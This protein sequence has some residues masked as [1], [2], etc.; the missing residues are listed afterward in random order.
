MWHPLF[1][2]N[3][4]M[5]YAAGVGLTALFGTLRVARVRRQRWADNQS[6]REL[7]VRVERERSGLLG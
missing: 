4:F 1:G 3:E 6:W 2:T 5:C 7:M